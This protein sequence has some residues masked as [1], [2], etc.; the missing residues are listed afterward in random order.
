MQTGQFARLTTGCWLYHR[1]SIPDRN[2]TFLF[3]VSILDVGCTR[4]LAQWVAGSKRPWRE[5][6][7]SPAPTAE[8]KNGYYT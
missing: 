4:P 3:M 6:N 8:V 2:K 7:H 5:A 1:A